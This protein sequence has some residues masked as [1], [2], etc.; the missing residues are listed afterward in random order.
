MLCWQGKFNCILFP[1]T[2]FSSQTKHFPI[3]PSSLIS[4]KPRKNSSSKLN[5]RA[6]IDSPTFCQKSTRRISR[7][8][9]KYGEPKN[10]KKKLI[11][12]FLLLRSIVNISNQLEQKPNNQHEFRIFLMFFFNTVIFG[13]IQQSIMIF[14]IISLRIIYKLFCRANSAANLLQIRHNTPLNEWT[15][16]RYVLSACH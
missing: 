14:I 2:F 6:N 3:S 16:I 11:S 5:Q 9:S 7:N 10:S 12:H 4:V 1:P 15:I 8:L 13:S